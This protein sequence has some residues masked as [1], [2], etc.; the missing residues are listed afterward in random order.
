MDTHAAP[1][2]V[3]LC[4]YTHCGVKRP[5]PCCCLRQRKR[6]RHFSFFPTLCLARVFLISL[7]WACTLPVSHTHTQP[8]PFSLGEIHTHFSVR[9]RRERRFRFFTLWIHTAEFSPTKDNFKLNKKTDYK[10]VSDSTD[11]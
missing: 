8:P 7:I 10:G 4:S 11:L 1:L 9:E 6:E 3:P 2:S 5:P